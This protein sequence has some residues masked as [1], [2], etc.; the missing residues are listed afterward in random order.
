MSIDSVKRQIE[1]YK[2]ISIEKNL[3]L[4]ILEMIWP[5]FVLEKVEMQITILA[6]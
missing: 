5:K 6:D 4:Q 3:E 2:E 1:G